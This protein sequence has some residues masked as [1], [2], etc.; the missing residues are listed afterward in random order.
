MFSAYPGPL[1]P[2]MPPSHQ[3][4]PAPSLMDYAWQAIQAGAITVLAKYKA[5]PEET[6]L[7]M[8]EAQKLY[9]GGEINLLTAYT[10]LAPIV[11][12]IMD[13]RKKPKPPPVKPPGYLPYERKDG[14]PSWVVPAAVAAGVIG[15]V[16]V[17]AR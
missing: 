5:T 9:L 7:V 3:I 17:V 11:S 6:A 1:E 4:P 14:I 16:F 10:Q 15:I 8:S 2:V 13:A 12:R